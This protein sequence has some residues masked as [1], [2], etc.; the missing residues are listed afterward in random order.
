[1]MFNFMWS[2]VL[3]TPRTLEVT[4]KSSMTPLPAVLAL[5]DTR[6]YICPMNSGNKATNIET[7][8]NK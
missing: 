7:T 4:S 2:I 6:I 1:M 3:Y 8:I 5:Q